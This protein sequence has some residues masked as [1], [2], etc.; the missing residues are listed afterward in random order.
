MRGSVTGS[1]PADVQAVFDRFVTCEL[2]TIDGT[3]QP[4]T[5]P[6]TPYYSPGD[7][8]IDITTGLGYPKKANDARANPLVSLLFSDPTGS[9]LAETPMVLVHGSAEVDDGDLEANRE[10]YSRESSQKLPALSRLMPPPAIRRSFN[11]YFMRIYIHVRPER[12]YVWPRGDLAAEPQLYDA[13]MEEVRSGHSEEPE[14]F[15]ADPGGGASAWDPR[16]YELGTRYPTAVLSIAS[17]DG[18]PFSIRVPVAVD[19]AAR[20][21]RIEGELTGVPLQPGLACLT[22]HAH[23]DEFT[24]MQNFQLRG[25]LVFAEGG[26]ALIPHRLVGG[27]ELPRSRLAAFRLNVA[28][29]RRFRRTAKRELARRG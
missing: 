7:P 20:W 6:V 26:W 1:L 18:F 27:L 29:A 2:T 19:E 14:R 22:A 12:V 8:C 16:I 21:V 9:G 15:H 13:H 23:G 28:K 4:V 3:G 24:W 5:W 11:W 10:R 25:D 17:P